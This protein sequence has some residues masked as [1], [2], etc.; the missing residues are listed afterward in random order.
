MNRENADF[1]VPLNVGHRTSH[2]DSLTYTLTNG[3]E[4]A[5]QPIQLVVLHQDVARSLHYACA[6]TVRVLI[7]ALSHFHAVVAST[8][9]AA[10]GA[11]DRY[12]FLSQLC[13][14]RDR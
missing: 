6:S 1:I 2:R 3:V 8:K 12:A 14:N 4:I 7:R 11:C 9:G 13:T 5:V 10:N